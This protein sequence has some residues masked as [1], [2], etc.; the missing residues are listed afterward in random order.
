MR[1]IH[2][3]PNFSRVAATLGLLAL[4]AALPAC[5]IKGSSTPAA[6]NDRLRRER[7]E[8]NARI[9][10]LEN[11]VAEQNAKIGELTRQGQSPLP[12]DVLAAL[13]RCAKVEIDSFS[14]FTPA[15]RTIPATGA[16][17]L[18]NPVDG[19]GRFVQVAGTL[20]VEAFVIPLGS[21]ADSDNTIRASTTLGPA[22][23]R[24]AYRSGLGSTGYE[25][26]LTFDTPIDPIARA[27]S[28]L[29]VRV[30]FLD[31]MTGEVHKAQRLIDHATPQRA[32]SAATMPHVN[33]MR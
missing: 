3:T 23:I 1:R 26:D 25:I 7:L 16:T 28:T 2:P 19:R 33:A 11:Q 15:Q 31:A 29:L 20:L 5:R 22:Q 32:T 9:E 4:A 21:S 27:G 13:P 10:S 17:V 12:E 8:L 18:V 14:G 30:E 6:E 24:D